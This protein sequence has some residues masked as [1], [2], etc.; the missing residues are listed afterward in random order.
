MI[1]VYKDLLTPIEMLRNFD[2][3]PVQNSLYLE[4]Y[5]KHSLIIFP[6]PE[7]IED[8]ENWIKPEHHVSYFSAFSTKVELPKVVGLASDPISVCQFH[9]VE[10]IIN[11]L[12]IRDNEIQ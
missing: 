8:F 11:L 6:N 2:R 3:L 5:L 12:I 10:V 4:P 9:V 1:M 7:Y